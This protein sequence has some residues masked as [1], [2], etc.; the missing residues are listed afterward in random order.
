[1]RS[2]TA[3][4]T[5]GQYPSLSFS[6]H[7]GEALAA[8]VNEASSQLCSVL[9]I[10]VYQVGRE[11]SERSPSIRIDHDV[12]VRIVAHDEAPRRG[13][14]MECPKAHKLGKRFPTL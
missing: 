5:R 6:I 7:R 9:L 12:P 13:G 10:R 8:R 3:H 14:S 4:I 11:E 1:M 2:L